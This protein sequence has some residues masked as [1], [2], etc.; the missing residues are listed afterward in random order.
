MYLLSLVY[1]TLNM[2]YVL[3]TLGIKQIKISTFT[4]MYKPNPYA[5]PS[6]SNKSAECSRT[7]CTC[8]GCSSGVG[9]GVRWMVVARVS[10]DLSMR[11]IGLTLST[12]TLSTTERA[13]LE[14]R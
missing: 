3:S 11:V 12:M 6:P 1:D 5:R 10:N 9:S 14:V 4:H 2:R 13:K 8:A 7:C